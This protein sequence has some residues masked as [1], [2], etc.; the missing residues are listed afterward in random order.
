MRACPDQ[1]H[2]RD[3]IGM[4]RS[5]EYECGDQDSRVSA[6]ASGLTECESMHVNE[7]L[8]AVRAPTFAGR[9]TRQTR[10]LMGLVGTVLHPS[11][12]ASEFLI[13]LTTN[14]AGGKMTN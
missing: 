5:M 11:S 1:V 4:T 14:A 3:E 2:R 12:A 9:V 6:V 10:V 13:G 7:D 8:H